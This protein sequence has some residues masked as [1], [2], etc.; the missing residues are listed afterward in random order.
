MLVEIRIIYKWRKFESYPS[1]ITSFTSVDLYYVY[2]E[3]INGVSFKA[4]VTCKEH[5]SMYSETKKSKTMEQKKKDISW[6]YENY[7]KIIE[8]I[9]SGITEE[10][11]ESRFN[12]DSFAIKKIN[13]IEPQ[14]KKT[15]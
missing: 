4:C 2:C 12:I 5:N 15:K 14:T 3:N 1:D 8:L 13:S 10:E 11:F 6:I 7:E 9:K